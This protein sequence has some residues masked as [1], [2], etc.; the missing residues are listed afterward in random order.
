MKRIYTNPVYIRPYTKENAELNA[1]RLTQEDSG[2][3]NWVYT[4]VQ[5]DASRDWWSIKVWEPPTSL[6]PNGVVLGYI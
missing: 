4:A 3:D 6:T 5:T 1:E 2:V